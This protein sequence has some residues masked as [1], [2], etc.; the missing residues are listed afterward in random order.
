MDV[1]KSNKEEVR[2]LTGN[3]VI[4]IASGTAVIVVDR[5]VLKF[6]NNL[7]DLNFSSIINFIFSLI[8]ALFTILIT[9]GVLLFCIFFII[10][11]SIKHLE[12]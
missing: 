10:Y 9:V 4:G 11:H 3:I 6:F 8:D 2:K 12:K 7:P 5:V 1:K